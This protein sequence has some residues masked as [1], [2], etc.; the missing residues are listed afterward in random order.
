[1]TGTN[2]VAYLKEL[3]ANAHPSSWNGIPDN[4]IDSN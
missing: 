1:M 2:L 4:A 3:D